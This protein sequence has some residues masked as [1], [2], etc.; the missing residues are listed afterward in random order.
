MTP[1]TPGLRRLARHVNDGFRIT[2][3][4]S[5]DREI[6]VE[7]E[8]PDGSTTV[9]LAREDAATLLQARRD[10]GTPKPIPA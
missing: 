3:I 2:E 9:S 6:L 10:R 1:T 8:G 4:T 7:L 5:S